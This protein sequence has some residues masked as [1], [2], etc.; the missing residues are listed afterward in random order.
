MTTQVEGVRAKVWQPLRRVTDH[1]SAMYWIAPVLLLGASLVWVSNHEDPSLLARLQDLLSRLVKEGAPLA[2]IAVAA[3]VPLASGGVDISTSGVATIGGVAFAVLMQV[4]VPP[5]LAISTAVG[6]GTSS[7]VLL[8]FLVSRALPP[9][10]L[11][12]AFGVLWLITAL[13]LADSR[14]A[15]S[16]TSGVSLPYRL[17][18]DYWQFGQGGFN[19]AVGFLSFVIFAVSMTNLP[20]RARAVGANRDSAIY[21]GIRT[22][23]VYLLCYGLSGSLA[24]LAGVLW[25]EINRGARTTDFVGTELTAVA[26]AILGGTVMS[27][28]YLFVPSVVASAGFWVALQTVIDGADLN[29]LRAFKNYQQHLANG[30]FALLFIAVLLPLGRRLNGPTQTISAEQRVQE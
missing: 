1:P 12:W 13:V 11:S 19:K 27:G 6:I 2:L 3:S 18:D 8:G 15:S 5:W 20:R 30:L 28:G 14:L 9:L 24:A 17:P 10:V 7:G 29:W 26:I 23:R 4:D 22:R 25:A 16:N 21:A